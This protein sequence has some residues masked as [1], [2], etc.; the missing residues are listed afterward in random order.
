[1]RIVTQDPQDAVIPG[2]RR[3]RLSGRRQECRSIFNYTGQNLLVRFLR[4]GFYSEDVWQV[5]PG[6]RTKLGVSLIIERRSAPGAHFAAST[7]RPGAG[8][9]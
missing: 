8:R 5:G 6:R 1:M 7:N 4:N 3:D 9:R 2:S